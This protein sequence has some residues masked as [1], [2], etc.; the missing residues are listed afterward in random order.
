[1]L[2][3]IFSKT[4][5]IGRVQQVCDQ[6]WPQCHDNTSDSLSYNL[7]THYFDFL[8][9]FRTL[10]KWMQWQV[11][12]YIWTRWWMCVVDMGGINGTLLFDNLVFDGNWYK[13]GSI[14]FDHFAVQQV[15]HQLW[16]Q[17]HGNTS[18]SLSYNLHT[19]YFDFLWKFRTL[20]NECNDKWVIYIWT[21]WWMCVVDMGGINGTLLFDN[22]VFDGNWY[23]WGSIKFDPFFEVRFV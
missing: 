6:L 16:P 19:H 18:D 10:I 15:C 7:Y 11:G 9:K 20:I 5:T 1:M 21:H 8:W 2:I 22:M 14:K 13:W 4:K 17:C 23:K 12:D 3:A